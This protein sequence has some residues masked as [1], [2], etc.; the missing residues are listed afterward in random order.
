MN[1][2]TKRSWRSVSRSAIMGIIEMKL[3]TKNTHIVWNHL[4]K[5]L[6]WTKQPHHGMHENTEKLL[7]KHIVQTQAKRITQ[8]SVFTRTL[9]SW[10]LT[11]PLHQVIMHARRQSSID[12]WYGSLISSNLN[13][14]AMRHISASTLL[15]DQWPWSKR[16]SRTARR[17]RY[18]KQTAITSNLMRAPS[19]ML[20]FK[21]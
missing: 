8:A 5:K 9:V 4:I 18:A 16:L 6:F 2:K 3:D 11:T 17:Q 20:L 1:K 21:Y 19:M 14:G 7:R 13:G 10:W 15:W 12:I